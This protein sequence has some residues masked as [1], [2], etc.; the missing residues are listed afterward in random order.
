MCGDTPASDV[1]VKL[2]DD[3]LGKLFKKYVKIFLI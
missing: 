1:R 3:D 2:I